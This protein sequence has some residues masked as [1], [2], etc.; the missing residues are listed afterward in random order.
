MNDAYI[1]EEQ[2]YSRYSWCLNSP[3]SVQD[4]LLRFQEELDRYEALDGWQREESRANLY[5]F[6][7]AVACTA[8]DYFTLSW[9]NSSP[10]VKCF[11]HLRTP[12][13]T[14]RTVTDV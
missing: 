12:I 4:L 14:V 8:D 6:V 5:L 10:L 7:C 2:F 13:E 3:L 1:A 11:P 9:F